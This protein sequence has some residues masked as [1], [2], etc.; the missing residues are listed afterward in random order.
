MRVSWR[1]LWH[2]LSRETALLDRLCFATGAFHLGDTDPWRAGAARRGD[3]S[4]RRTEPRWLAATLDAFGAPAAPGPVPDG[5]AP[6]AGPE[7][8]AAPVLPP[9]LAGMAA[10]STLGAAVPGGGA[11]ARAAA[12]PHAAAGSPT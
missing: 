6:A 7:Q 2:V 5:T 4:S 12:G 1:M 11:A 3:G 8:P 9:S 10:S